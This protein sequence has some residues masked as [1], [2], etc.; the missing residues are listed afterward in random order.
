VFDWNENRMRSTLGVM[1]AIVF[2]ALVAVD[3]LVCPDG[4]AEQGVEI[5]PEQRVSHP[6]EHPPKRT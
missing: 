4:C 1:L 6:I 5:A 3:P 2:V